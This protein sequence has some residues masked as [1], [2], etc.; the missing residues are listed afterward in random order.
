MERRLGRMIRSMSF[1]RNSGFSASLNSGSLAVDIYESEREVLVYMDVAGVEPEKLSV[2]LE[3]N[4][5]TVSGEREFPLLELCCIHQ[6][7]LDYGPFMR[8]IEL[9]V[10]IDA[11]HATS[12][13]RNGFLVVRM[14]KI[15]PRGKVTI[16]IR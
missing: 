6:L 13:C 10:Q 2:V 12:I 9:P 1:S 16:P 4:R 5:L 15:P 7:E 3:K 14:P 8:T 11:D